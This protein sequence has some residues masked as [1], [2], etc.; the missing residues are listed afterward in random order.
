MW[1]WSRCPEV[2]RCGDGHGARLSGGGYGAL[3][4]HNVVMVMVSLRQHSCGGGLGAL[5]SD[6]GYGAPEVAQCGGGHGDLRWHRVVVVMVPGGGTMW[7]WPG[8][9]KV[10]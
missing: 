3:G 6:G 2:A 7:W 5:Q 4:W 8:C 10:V 9:T 1:W